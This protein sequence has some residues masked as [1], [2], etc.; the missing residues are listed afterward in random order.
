M[1]WRPKMLSLAD[2]LNLVGLPFKGHPVMGSTDRLAVNLW[3]LQVRKSTLNIF[4]KS[5]EVNF[6]ISQG[7]KKIGLLNLCRVWPA[8]V[9]LLTRAWS[10]RTIEGTSMFWPILYRSTS[11]LLVS[12]LSK[13]T[14][15]SS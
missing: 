7:F 9:L 15:V 4:H 3:P 13:P 8:A 2:P 6:F 11:C 10:C 12:C 1:A 5:I 14:A